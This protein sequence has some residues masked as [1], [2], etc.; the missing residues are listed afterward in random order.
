MIV[1][2]KPAG[3]V[4]HPGSGHPAR[5][6]VNGLLAQFPELRDV[7]DPQRPG[8]VHRLDRD[9]SGLLVVART[10]S[11]YGTLVRALAA[12]EVEREYRRSSGGI[13]TRHAA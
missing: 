12:H 3:L 10:P 6:L 1:V 4:V 7:G 11:V 5:T 9:T 8:I 13:S 2:A